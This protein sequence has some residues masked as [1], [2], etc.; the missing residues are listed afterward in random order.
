MEKFRN[1]RPFDISSD[2]FL[3][4]WETVLESI[5]DLTRLNIVK[6]IKFLNPRII[7]VFFLLFVHCVFLHRFIFVCLLIILLWSLIL[8]WPLFR[9][10]KQKIRKEAQTKGKKYLHSLKQ[11]SRLQIFSTGLSINNRKA[12]RNMSYKLTLNDWILV[13]VESRLGQVIKRN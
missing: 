4:V 10:P 1:L 2:S 5:Y 8:F 3:F 7:W 9:N 12:A 11:N 13:S 6:Q